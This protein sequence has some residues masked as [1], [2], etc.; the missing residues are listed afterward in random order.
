MLSNNEV[1]SQNDNFYLSYLDIPSLFTQD[2]DKHL[3]GADHPGIGRSETAI[4]ITDPD[5]KCLIL[6]GDHREGYTP[7]ANDLDKCTKYWQDHSSEVAHT[8]D[9]LDEITTVE[10][11]SI[12]PEQSIQDRVEVLSISEKLEVEEV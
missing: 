6:Y 2:L 7:I 12:V 4:C 10:E 8:S 5:W 3:V 1:F 9:Y 11:I